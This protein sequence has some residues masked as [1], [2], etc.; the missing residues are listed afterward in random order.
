MREFFCNKIEYV[1]QHKKGIWWALIYI[2]V[3]VSYFPFNYDFGRT[4]SLILP[5]DRRIPFLKEFVLVYDLWFPFLIVNLTL[6]Y[7]SS[8]ELYT[9]AVRTLVITQLLAYLTFALFQTYVPRPEIVGN[10]F[11]SELMRMTYAN[12]R[13]YCGFP[14]VHVLSTFIV[15]CHVLKTNFR[16]SYK[17]VV[18]VIAI[19]IILSTVFVKQHVFLDII[20]G[21]GYSVIVYVV[22]GLIRDMLKTFER[23]KEKISQE[24]EKNY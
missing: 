13:P 17:A 4:V 20:G 24:C 3:A 11:F 9:S 10:D 23:R 2:L 19:L 21:I 6:L 1:K 15:G 5:I 12:D 16:V 14:S 8:I 18:S 7:F 22:V